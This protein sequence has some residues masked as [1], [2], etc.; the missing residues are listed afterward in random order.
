MVVALT[1]NHTHFFRERH[2]F[3]HFCSMALPGVQ[4]R[5]RREPIRMWSAGCST[6]EEVYSLAMCLLG[7]AKSAAAW[8]HDADVRLLATDLAPHVVEATRAGVFTEAAVRPVPAPYRSAWM[9]QSG[10]EYCMDPAAREL[11]TAQVLNLFDRWPMR[12]LFD[13][14]FC[15]NVMIY[16]DDVAKAELE[17]RLVDSLVPGGFLYIGHSERL[18]GPAA[19][20]MISCGQTVYRKPGPDA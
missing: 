20:A 4:S 14:I 9:H 13:V 5:A 15:R 11:V 12:R 16:F 18:I 2:H 10:N 17:A 3:D 7:P 6:G 1:T 19:A 8:L